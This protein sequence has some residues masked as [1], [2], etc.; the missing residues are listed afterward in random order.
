[1]LVWSGR[2]LHLSS[3]G[4]GDTA[5]AVTTTTGPS[6]DPSALADQPRMNPN[7]LSETLADH[8]NTQ[9]VDEN[10]DP[11]RRYAALGT[12]PKTL[13]TAVRTSALRTIIRFAGMVAK[14]RSQMKTWG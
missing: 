9:S 1:M 2:R 8:T 5:G 10:G 11:V 14:F 7:R 12:H 6:G 3:M 4:S 13:R